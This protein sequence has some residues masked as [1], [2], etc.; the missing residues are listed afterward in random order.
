[1]FSQFAF[2]WAVSGLNFFCFYLFVFRMTLA[3]GWEF[4]G[5]RTTARIFNDRII[6]LSNA[7][8]DDR[9]PFA[10]QNITRKE[11]DKLKRDRINNG[12]RRK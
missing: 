11:P 6:H 3:N 8:P 10:I 12:L 1:M 5:P 7:R 4:L 9:F 2:G